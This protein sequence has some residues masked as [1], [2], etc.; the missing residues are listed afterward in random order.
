[1]GTIKAQKIDRAEP[2]SWWVG[3]ET[4][5]Q[6]M[7]YGEGLHGATV[8]C[9]GEGV[10]VTKVYPAQNDR[11]LFADVSVAADARPGE[12][13]FVIRGGRGETA[14]KYRIDERRKGSRDR[15][16]FTS[17]DAVYLLMPD[18]FANGDPSNDDTPDTREKA[19]RSDKHGRHGG[20]IQGIIDRLDYLA[21]LGVTAV[22]STPLLLD[23]EPAYSYHGYAC[24]DY[25]RIDPRYG[26]N[27]LYRTMVDEAHRRG[28]KVI[29]DMVPNHCGAAHRWMEALPLPDWVHTFDT[30]TQTNN[31]FSTAADPNAS[32]ADKARCVD[33]WFDK[34]MPDMNLENPFVLNYFTQWAVWWIEWAGLDGLRV[35][36]FPYNPKEQAAR[37]VRAIRAEYPNL[38]IVGECWT[39][40]PALAAYWDGDSDNR[41]GYSSGLPSVM[42]FPLQ[43]ALAGA[44]RKD[45]VGWGEGLAK[46]Y[47]VLA[48]DFL[49][50]DPRKL[51]IFAG[52]HDTDRLAWFIRSDPDKAKLVMTMLATLRGVPQLYYGDEVMLLGDR[53]E[54]HGGQR[55]DF[56]GGWAGDKTDLFSD[57]KRTPARAQ[58]FDHTRRLFNWRKGAKAVH[59][60]RT[61][62]FLPVGEVYVYFR[63]TDEQCV[64]VVVNGSRERQTLDW[65]RFAEM[66]DGY[67]AGTDI[68]SGRAFR[69]GEPVGVEPV[70]SMVIELK[71]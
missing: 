44:F 7:F 21:D 37:W 29:M 9:S 1:M 55:I 71:R 64:M 14:Y 8:S 42:D 32:Q 27:E 17:A 47:D 58:V 45:T 4:P 48:H 70:G 30:F 6:I 5:L 24:A 15:K 22:W 12:Y 57:R 10:T 65:S 20:D 36:T 68:L 46:V 18:R 35:D 66:T 62:H 33:G 28:L 43:E 26:S 61:L 50:P 41:D 53:K 31:A 60:G 56:P 40:S 63:Y 13:T 67:S 23:D 3:M 38:N 34:P 69:I 54:G 11:Y 16:S 39:S 49:Y 25:Y 51:M 52:N 19:D 59:E 2:L